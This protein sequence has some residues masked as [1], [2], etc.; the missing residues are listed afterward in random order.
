MKAHPDALPDAARPAERRTLPDRRP[1]DGEYPWVTAAWDALDDAR[2][3]AAAD[4]LPAQM[5]AAAERSAGPA[6]GVPAQDER[7][8]SHWAEE[9]DAAAAPGIRGADRSAAR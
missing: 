6:P 9:R 4:A 5:G 1:A 2:P 7:P 3:D 8:H